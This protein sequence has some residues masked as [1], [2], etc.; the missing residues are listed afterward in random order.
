MLRKVSAWAHRLIKIV[1]VSSATEVSPRI[2][3][4]HH[5]HHDCSR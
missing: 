4:G 1:A 3:P 5:H 2:F